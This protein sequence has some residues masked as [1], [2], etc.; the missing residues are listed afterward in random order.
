MKSRIPSAVLALGLATAVL[1]LGPAAAQP[2]VVDLKEWDQADLRRGWSAEA[3][4]EHDVYGPDGNEI[5]EVEDILIGS[6]DEVRAI[7]VETDA[8]LDIGDV[9]A[10]VAWDKVSPGPEPNSVSVPVSEETLEEF[11][12]N[13][14]DRIV[15]RAWRVN[16]LIGDPVALEDQRGYGIVDDVVFGE[17]GKVKG[18]IVDANYRS[19]Y[20]VGPYAYPYYGRRRGWEPGLG[21]YD[22]PYTRKE[23]TGY[24]PYEYEPKGPFAGS[25]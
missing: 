4:L 21:Y 16:E 15:P 7:I 18:I 11:R 3:L 6:D 19:G 20:G 5:G 10:Q 17:N 12:V 13:Y 25:G 8:F 22:L 2:V 1:H 24:A 9:H 23:V 14:D